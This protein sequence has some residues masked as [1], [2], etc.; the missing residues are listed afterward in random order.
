MS[1]AGEVEEDEGERGG[2]K[3]KP[4]STAAINCWRG[5]RQVCEESAFFQSFSRYEYLERITHPGFFTSI[6]QTNA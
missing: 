3:A 1:F 4:L 5:N 2:R 6:S